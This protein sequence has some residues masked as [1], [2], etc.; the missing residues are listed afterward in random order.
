MIRSPTPTGCRTADNFRSAR[1]RTAATS[2]VGRWAY[3][4][5]S[6]LGTIRPR[7]T[8]AGLTEPQ[9]PVHGRPSRTWWLLFG[10]AGQIGAGRLLVEFLDDSPCEGTAH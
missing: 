10:S 1:R 3:G 9:G 6:V 2:P 8:T 7:T 4:P 5:R